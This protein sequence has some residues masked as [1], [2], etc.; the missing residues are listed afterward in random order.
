MLNVYIEESMLSTSMLSAFHGGKQHMC[1]KY[2]KVN[3]V[4]AE[5]QCDQIL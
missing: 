5:G 1:N 4:G 3:K 2:T